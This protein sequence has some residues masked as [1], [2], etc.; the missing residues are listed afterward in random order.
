MRRIL[1][2]LA[3]SAMAGVGFAGEAE[4]RYP[5]GSPT[6]RGLTEAERAAIADAPL[7]PG[8][9]SGAPAGEA[10]AVA[11]YEPME[12]IIV[13]YEG[14]SSWRAV[15][16][17]MGRHITTTGDADLYVVCDTA[18]E[19]A[20]A[21]SEFIAAGA[22]PSRVFTKVRTTDTIW[23]R[24]Y[25]P[26]YIYESGIRAI[27]DHTYNRPRPN[28]NQLPSFWGADRGEPVYTIPLVHGG[29]NY[30]LDAIGGAAATRLIEN[31]N[32]G[33][34][35]SEII[36]L[37]RD[38]QG[39]ET[40]LFDPLPAFVDS[41]QH[42]D[43][44]MQIVADDAI[45]ISD[46]PLEP[47]SSWDAICDAAAA[48]FAAAGWTVTRT[49]A[50]RQFGT[51]YTF[52]N[53]VMC[54]DLVLVPEYDNISATYSQ[55]ALAAWEAAVPNK[56]V[57][58][59]DCDAIVT[60]SGVMHCIVMHVPENSGGQNP[61]A[62]ATSP[63]GGSFDAGETVNL[64][65]RT[66]DDL[67]VVSVDLLFRS[68]AS[69]AFEVIAEA[70]PDTGSFAWTAPNVTTETGTIRVVARDAD[71]R[72]GFD[73]TDRPFSITGTV[74]E[75]PGDTNGDSTVDLTDLLTLLANFGQPADNGPADGDFDGSGSVDLPDL[76]ALLA[77]FGSDC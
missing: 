40:V 39:V 37:W 28:D 75:C 42:I 27:V 62:W 25:G 70:I 15:L 10:R 68:A 58:Q 54:N 60:A 2:V 53:V 11:E 69:Q 50:V 48:D 3:F 61:V 31:E 66:D 35:G 67:A 19:A 57:V 71:G 21:Q 17:D 34:T 6:P 1:S 51:H 44:W 74:N 30:H 47:G 18:S 9:S 55:Q 20:S 7:I 59:V 38:F 12:G 63:D 23:V 65:W 4:D 14:P 72:T 56:T 13:A 16:R 64:E 45:V 36:D 77:A 52:T 43:M 29:G 76:L 8:R 73:D 24:D 22:N 26:R 49:P 46:W 41:T 33:L 32:P 5:E